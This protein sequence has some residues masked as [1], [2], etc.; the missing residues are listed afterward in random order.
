M[1]KGKNV[2]VTGAT[3]GIGKDIAIKFAK[4]GANIGIN[5]VI[6]EEAANIVIEELKSVGGN[7]IYMKA[8]VSNFEEV[9]NMIKEFE[10]TFG[11]VDILVNN[12]G[13]TR[14]N[15]LIRM[16]DNEWDSVININL[17]GTF[18]CIKAVSRGMMKKRYGKIINI[19]SIVGFSGNPGQ[20]N[21]VASKSGVMGLTKTAALELAARGIRVNAVAPGFIDTDMTK[22]LPDDVKKSM[23]EKI[24]LGIFGKPEDV[25]NAVFFLASP[26]S[27]YI[28]GQVIHVNGG[29]YM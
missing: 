7:A 3:R 13:I 27:D 14:D 23:A 15:L 18:N 28:T 1:F 6:D 5:D 4:Q 24:A 16:T 20:A 10:K 8:D 21:Y 22:K 2:L 26:D 12:A 9:K 17:K 11:G 29:M 25:A 19:S